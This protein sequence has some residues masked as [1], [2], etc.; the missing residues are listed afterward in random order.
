MVIVFFSA[1]SP[2]TQKGQNEQNNDDQADEI[3]QAIHCVSSS[4]SAIAL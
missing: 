2:Q 4:M 3:N 1:P